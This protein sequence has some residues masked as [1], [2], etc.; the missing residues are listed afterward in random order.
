MQRSIL[1][2]FGAVMSSKLLTLLVGLVTTPVLYR[3]LGPAEFG[4]YAFLLSAFS[5]YMI[6]VS[7]GVTEGVRKFLAEDRDHPGWDREVVGFYLR[8]AVLFAV[9]G[10]GVVYG[11]TRLGLVRRFLGREFV[12]YFHL[13]AA[14]VITTQFREV[15]R[16]TLMGF[17]LERYSEPLKALRRI[18]FVLVALPLAFLGHGV[19][20]V[21]AAL[22]VADV[23]VVA[24]SLVFIHREVSLVAALGSTPD[25]LPRRSLLSFN[26]LSVVLILLM[27][28]LYHV[29]I[30]LLQWFTGS[31][32]VGNYKVAL[33]MA[34]FLWFVPL[35]I[36]MVFVHSMS[37][38]WSK[39]RRERVTRVTTLSTRYTFLLTAVM[40]LGLAA[41]A[42]VAVPLYFGPEA[43]PAVEP[44]VLL[45][46]GALGFAVARPV[47][48]ASQGKGDLAA[49]IVA[50]GTAA[51][52]NLGLN[53][54]L[55]PRF[56]MHGAAV[57]T[58]A[59]YGVMFVTHVWA[60]RRLG[61]DPL[62]DARLP[63]VAV[64]TVVAA[65]PILALPT[66][67]ARPLVALVVVPPVGLAVYAGVAF[68]TGALDADEC[69]DV[70]CS[71][72]LAPYVA[73]VERTVATDGGT[74]E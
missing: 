28:S 50:T 17:G 32:Q 30:I 54:L 24:G 10:A 71:T 33:K 49:P 41:L 19:A 11:V 39:G 70:L 68:A 2:G 42:D 48:A 40:A 55:I 53:L 38:L 4:V 23:V 25:A 31:T 7:S 26:T 18:L 51:G 22:V 72:P 74:D 43:T 12:P 57:A 5:L 20:G 62:A 34:E 61:F 45:L 21:L 27:M 66:L 58:S 47:L 59:G 9:L 73:S 6:L 65:V 44:L 29:D 14:M 69:R 3:L 15:T 63:R 13:L 8:L 37:N 60:A 67:I 56:G 35:A 46:P 64:T 36:Q 52:V 1:E 16:R